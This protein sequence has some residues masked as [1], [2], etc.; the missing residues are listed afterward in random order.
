MMSDSNHPEVDKSTQLQINQWVSNIID[1]LLEGKSNSQIC[2][3]MRQLTGKSERMVQRYLERA[4][5]KLKEDHNQETAVKRALHVDGL[6]KDLKEAYTNYLLD[7]SIH[8]FKTYQDIKKEL[9]TFEPDDLRA[10]T[11]LDT[12]TIN[13]TYGLVED[14]DEG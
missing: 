14:E 9:K 7:K 3:E 11:E 8:W 1:L 4:N 5:S 13:I 12:Q 10:K 2:D 6:R